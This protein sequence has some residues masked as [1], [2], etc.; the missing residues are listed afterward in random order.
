MVSTL[1]LILLILRLGVLFYGVDFLC[2]LKDDA[3]VGALHRA[4][5]VQRHLS[6]MGHAKALDHCTA[7][8]LGNAVKH[9]LQ[10]Y[11]MAQGGFHTVC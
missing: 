6:V 1:F 7:T 4:K 11:F 9:H 10:A 2:L 8:A 3:M 5:A